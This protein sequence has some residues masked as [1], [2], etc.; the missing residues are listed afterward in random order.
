MSP[1]Q[2]LLMP[3]WLPP[4]PSLRCD[5]CL[6]F[7]SAHAIQVNSAGSHTFCQV[8]GCTCRLIITSAKL[9]WDNRR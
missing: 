3:I 4:E 1:E 8:P 7:H 9:F 6:H 2:R 5:M